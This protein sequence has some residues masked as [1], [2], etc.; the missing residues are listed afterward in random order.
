MRQVTKNLM[1]P[2]RNQ[3]GLGR[4]DKITRQQLPTASQWQAR[5]DAITWGLP[6]PV[7]DQEGLLHV[8]IFSMSVFCLTDLPHSHTKQLINIMHKICFLLNKTDSQTPDEIALTE[9]LKSYRLP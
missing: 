4:C 1:Q 6:Q 7:R 5:E 3:K 9:G 8:L 2:L